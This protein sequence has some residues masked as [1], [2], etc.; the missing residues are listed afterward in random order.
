[1]LDVSV[2]IPVKDEEGSLPELSNRLITTL[3]NMN[4]TYEI[5]FVTDINKD[6]TFS[7][8]KNLSVANSNIKAIKLTNGHGQHIAVLAGLHYCSGQ[9]VVIMDGDLQDY[10]EDIPN[11]YLKLS[12]GFDIVYGIKENK[13]ESF[14]KNL[15][16]KM[17]MAAINK[18]SD[19]RVKIDINMCM[20]RIISR[21][22]VE[23]MRK[24]KEAEPVLSFIMDL[25]GLPTSSINLSSGKRKAGNTKYNFFRK[26]N[27]AINS[28]VSF[29]T[30]PLRLISSIGFII[31]GLSFL[32]LCVTLIQTLFFKI[33]ILGWPTI[34]SLITFLGGM[35]LLGMG[36][37]GEYIS[38]IFIESKDR[39]LYII[40]EK[41]GGFNEIPI[42]SNNFNAGNLQPNNN[43]I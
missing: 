12:E 13:N 37:I 10:P 3:N 27:L 21:R 22:T 29:S 20:Y 19:S 43:E 33:G 8:I 6:N 23:A 35:Q 39:P 24:Y 42:G 36:I 15:F 41:V 28:I 2:I 18:L 5:I 4:R 1:M 38:K 40:D 26:L 34:I 11:L 14:F 9:A 30:K 17:F 25:T 32:Y 31:S 7:L 16:S